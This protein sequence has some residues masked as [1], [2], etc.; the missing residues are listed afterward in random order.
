MRYKNKFS[1]SIEAEDGVEALY[2]HQ[3]DRSAHLENAIYHGMAYADG[4]GRITVRAFR[5]GGDVVI[6]VT[7]N[8]RACPP[9]PWRA[10]WTRPIPPRPAPRARALGIAQCAPAHPPDAGGGYGLSIHSEPDAG[11]RVRVRLPALAAAAAAAY[12]RRWPREAKNDRAAWH[13]WWCW[14]WGCWF[15]L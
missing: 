4:D 14:A 9:G 11:T 13:F 15:P 7:D 5:E 1:A 2:H 6:D 12:L 10:C 8:G 3:T